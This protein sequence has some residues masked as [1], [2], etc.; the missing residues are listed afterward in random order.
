MSRSNNASNSRSGRNSRVA[1]FTVADQL[2]ITVKSRPRFSHSGNNRSN[3]GNKPNLNR[4]QQKVH[5]ALRFGNDD[6]GSWTISD[7]T[8]S[9]LA[10]INPTSEGQE[11]SRA[12]QV[13]GSVLDMK[14][15]EV[16][17]R[18]LGEPS[19]VVATTLEGFTPSRN[20]RVYRYNEGI[21]VRVM[22]LR[23]ENYLSTFRK[24]N[25]QRSELG[26]EDQQR[27]LADLW[28]EANGPD[29]AEMFD[30]D[31]P[32]SCTVYEFCLVTGV[33]LF[34]TRQQVERS[35]LVLLDTWEADR[36]VQGAPKGLYDTAA[37]PSDHLLLGQPVV[38]GG[39]VYRADPLSQ[40]QAQRHLSL[41]YFDQLAVDYTKS[42]RP[43][44]WQYF[45]PSEGLSV[46]HYNRNGLLRVTS[47]LSPAMNYRRELTMNRNSPV[48][49]F[50]AVVAM[51]LKH[52]C[53]L[54][55][56][57][58]ELAYPPEAPQVAVS[59]LFAGHP[60]VVPTKPSKVLTWNQD[61][62]RD[63]HLAAYL[64]ALPAF[65]RTDTMV[66]LYD[67]PMYYYYAYMEAMRYLQ[68][69][70]EFALPQS[71]FPIL[72]TTPLDEI[73][74]WEQ[75]ELRR[76]IDILYGVY[77][78]R[79]GNTV[80]YIDP[81]S[82]SNTRRALR[83]LVL[84][85]RFKALSDN[86]QMLLR[87]ALSLFTPFSSNSETLTRFPDLPIYGYRVGLADAEPVEV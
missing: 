80:N 40:E 72:T 62:I 85:D 39:V 77:Q 78:Y 23:G 73:R 35:Y 59:E 17:V 4:T 2:P 32:D 18:S 49:H 82:G 25:T 33:L 53:T 16:V 27:S 47:L 9:A 76:E 57:Q 58:S 67:R 71:I 19:T 12:A 87:E 28:A 61:Y 74:N 54:V 15:G 26:Y 22:R 70:P 31:A 6:V 48:A 10:V 50:D 60:F 63:L 51:P 5:R 81:V 13:R 45:V 84:S 37:L 29:A 24:L 3:H 11:T 21:I 41:G 43:D 7:R 65:K 46:Q 64:A 38:A 56:D 8:E 66:R 86:W 75:K 34:G 52:F 14:T 69:D 83:T 1:P 30:Q 79:L 44:D 55:P 42:R 36:G 68:P 20:T